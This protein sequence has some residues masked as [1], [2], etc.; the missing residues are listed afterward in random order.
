MGFLKHGRA[1]S[2][3]Y[4]ILLDDLK[5]LADFRTCVMGCIDRFIQAV[6]NRQQPLAQGCRRLFGHILGAEVDHFMPNLA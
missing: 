4:P 2:W 6:V 1:L 5:N 3:G